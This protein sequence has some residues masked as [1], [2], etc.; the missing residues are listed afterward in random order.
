MAM[1]FRDAQQRAA[2]TITSSEAQTLLDLAIQS[3][4]ELLARAVGNHALASMDMRAV[5]EAYLTNHPVQAAALD[6]VAAAP[7]ARERCD[8][9][10]V[11]RP[12]APGTLGNARRADRRLRRAGQQVPDGGLN[13]RDRAR[14]RHGAM[15]GRVGAAVP[16][17]ISNYP[18]HE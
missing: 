4:D 13:T 18:R 14:R 9:V 6:G 15:P 16:L 17:T 11:R 10:R 2:Q 1:S 5:A 3:G 8:H 12:E 7:A